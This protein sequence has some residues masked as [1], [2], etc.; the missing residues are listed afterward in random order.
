MQNQQVL[1]DSLPSGKLTTDNYRLSESAMPE[2]GRS[3]VLIKTIAFAITAGT[4]AGLQGSASYAGA[5]EAGRVMNGTGV[6]EVVASNATEFKVGD[7][8]T[9]ATGWQAYSVQDAKLVTKIDPSHDPIH[10]LG[11]LGINGLTAYFGLNEVGRPKAGETVM[12]SAAAGSVGHMVGQMARIA[13]CL[14]VG[15]CGSE[16][17]GRVLTEQLGFDSVVNYKD[18]NYRQSLKEATPNGVDVYFDNTGG[19]ILGSA[20]FRMNVAGRISCCGVVSQYDTNT[21]EPGP[22]GIPGLLVNNRITMRGFLVFDFAE[23][24][25]MA[26][27]QIHSWLQSGEMISLT[28]EVNGLAAAPEG[29]VDLLSGGNVGTRIVRL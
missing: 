17:K 29:F 13:G 12:V 27:K 14:T 23:Q 21:P 11:P 9:A 24:Y 3:Q 25:S 16:E 15:V 6:G 18:A 19:M 2:I 4:R 7:H 28:D 26:R 1:I 22:R 20:L 8:V 10:Y 5:P